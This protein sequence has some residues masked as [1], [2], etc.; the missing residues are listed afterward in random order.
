G[1]GLILAGRRS[2]ACVNLTDGSQRWSR[3]IAGSTGRG[4]LCGQEVLIPSDRTILRL[5]V[6]DGTTLGS[7]RAQ[8]MDNLPLGNLYVHG[9]QLLVVGLERLYALVDARPAFARLKEGLARNPTAE[10]YAE[11]GG[12]YAGLGYPA[13][14][15]AD[16]R[17]AWKLQRGL[18]GEESARGAL[19]KALWR[20][21]EQEPGAADTFG[22]E[23]QQITAAA[24]ERAEAIW[25]LAQYR[26]RAGSTHA[27][28]TLYAALIAAPDATL[29]LASGE[30]RWKTSTRRAAAQRLRTLLAND[31]P[32]YR[33]LL[34]K[35]AAQALAGLGATPACTTL[36][37]VATV[38]AGT[39]AGRDAAFQAARLAAE[40]GDLGTAE[41]IL[42]RAL[43]LSFP[44]ARAPVVEEL[45]RL[46]MDRMKWP[47]GVT[48][49]LEE[50]PQL[51][52]GLP[53][54]DAL[55]RASTN[56]VAMQRAFATPLPPWRLRW[57]G[58]RKA[59][60]TSIV[61][62]AGLLY[63]QS[64]N[65]ASYRQA[66]EPLRQADCGC[67]DLDTGKVRW[68]RDGLIYTVPFQPA[69]RKGMSSRHLISVDFS[70]NTG[71]GVMDLW[72]GAVTTNRIPTAKDLYGVSGNT[73][74]TR[75]GMAVVVRNDVLAGVDALTGHRIWSRGDLDMTAGY[76]QWRGMSSLAG[77]VVVNG[78][79]QED[80]SVMPTS[81]DLCSGAILSR[82]SFAAAREYGIW[83]PRVASLRSLADP[84]IIDFL[85]PVLENKRLSKRNSRTG[86][87]L[88][89]SPPDLAI[90][91]FQAIYDNDTVLAETESDELVVFRGADGKI[92]CRSLEKRFSYTQS[93]WASA[94]CSIAF[95]DAAPS[96]WT[97][98]AIGAG[99]A[100]AAFR[101]QKSGTN[102][103]M[104]LDP[105]IGTVTFH[106]LLPYRNEIQVM[107]IL[108]LA[109]AMTN[110]LM[111]WVK[112]QQDRS[113]AQDFIQIVNSQDTSSSG[114][115]LP[116]TADVRDPK[117]SYFTPFFARELIVM[118][119]SDETLAY[120]H[121][122][123]EGAKK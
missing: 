21:A 17:E 69:E 104:V 3:P 72:S 92:L 34:E 123:G 57:R 108:S 116:R 4:T 66:K 61:S 43:A 11:R 91:K 84:L 37:E 45:V 23:A 117:R 42:Q 31:E 63:S 88:W 8:T 62:P 115:R 96:M 60:A 75:I 52:G 41:V 54:P 67:L 77:A 65:E 35:P 120:E 18:A 14:A 78:S 46:Y 80:G 16:L 105:A 30:T 73:A 99:N 103:L 39:T 89:T 25:R 110:G 22:S 1:A 47:R 10:A 100:V 83:S 15:A 122:P 112:D 20:A 93:G 26:E 119:S 13:E 86:A 113:A 95:P 90:V 74:V 7:V 55:A 28:L 44:P 27:A 76:N 114:W 40:H 82:R 49:L 36:V 121:D 19:L 106:G 68:Q 94:L 38:F 102:E 6:E 9:S 51:G 81:F 48:Q 29:S 5:R 79:A 111:V 107:P 118:V 24:G 97:F 70:G 53:V 32:Q 58:E 101:S 85:D 98:G 109:P 71:D 2:V 56:A 33:A 12:L 50:W 64:G 59:A 87:V